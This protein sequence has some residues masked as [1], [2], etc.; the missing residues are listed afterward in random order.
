MLDAIQRFTKVRN[1]LIPASN[2]FSSPKILGFLF[3]RK[4]VNLGREMQKI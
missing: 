4:I 3:L 2:T 1:F